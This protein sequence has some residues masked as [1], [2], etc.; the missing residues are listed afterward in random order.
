MKEALALAV[1][2]TRTTALLIESV[3]GQPRLVAAGRALSSSFGPSGDVVAGA[4]AAVTQV[5]SAVGRTL[6][7]LGAL[8]TPRREDGAGVASAAIV[9][10]ERPTV[11]LV[12]FGDRNALA[13]ARRALASLDA[14]LDEPV[15][16]SATADAAELAERLRPRSGALTAIVVVGPADAPAMARLAEAVQLAWPTPGTIPPLLW[17]GETAGVAVAR[18]VLQ[19][20]FNLT[21]V[22][23]VRRGTESEELGPLREA[24]ADLWRE[25]LDAALPGA[26]TVGKWAPGAPCAWRRGEE[27]A[28]GYLATSRGGPVWLARLV[29]EELSLL[30]AEP[31]SG[32]VPPRVVGA[33]AEL[34]LLAR[35][36]RPWSVPGTP[37]AANDLAAAVIEALRAAAAQLPADARPSL[38]GAAGLLIAGGD[39]ALLP[40]ETLVHALIDGLEPS[41]LLQL[42]VDEPDAL[43]ALGALAAV[44]PAAAAPVL[45]GELLRP[46]GALVAPGWRGRAGG[47]SFRFEARGASDGGSLA[48]DGILADETRRVA[49]AEGRSVE[50]RALRPNWWDPR[51]YLGRRLRMTIEGGP[52]G[53]V[54]DGRARPFGSALSLGREPIVDD[55]A[56]P[57]EQAGPV[58]ARP[59]AAGPLALRR[60]R[61]LPAGARLLVAAGDSVEPDEL[62][63]QAPGRGDGANPTLLPAGKQ[64]GVAD[65]R[66]FLTRATGTRVQAGDVI[67]RRSTLFGLIQR[68]VVA[69]VD[70]VLAAGLGGFGNLA[71]VPGS[72]G[73]GIAAHLPGVVVGKLEDAIVIETKAGLIAGGVGFG[74]E[75][76]GLLL[77]T[78]GRVDGSS[79]A[80]AAGRLAGAVVALDVLDRPQ[81]ELLRAAGAAGVIVGSVEPGLA[82]E[83][84]LVDPGLVVIATEGV[85]S[86]PLPAAAREVLAAHVGGLACLSAGRADDARAWP[87]AIFPSA[88][89][90][91]ARAL[92][93]PALAVGSRVRVIG[94]AVQH[95]R[96]VAVPAA[97][98]RLASGLVTAV[99][100]VELEGGERVRPALSNLELV[101]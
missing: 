84:A 17:A 98:D 94:E 12:G 50:V 64:L 33:R 16:V 81:Y 5:E 60:A 86:A 43:A 8:L 63:A 82:A 38:A 66:P 29:G 72:D 76:R 90:E 61:P 101:G 77:P 21:I 62:V 27:I 40:V 74:G 88:T 3:D 1:S 2:S 30:H 22:G 31:A 15:E 56:A 75:R 67:A 57:V 80:R 34:G 52:V 28:L 36:L 41:G 35:S 70:G 18:A 13:S 65:P 46:L 92:P 24:V 100:E 85:G 58:V 37:S 45:T 26:G 42:A 6:F 95:G 68:T 51:R 39:L 47:L 79:E 93:E 11:R 99:V 71:I 7:A 53:L 87:E 23:P 96:V 69:P 44:A 10:E 14:R 25:R 89:A 49:L 32:D 9:F 4:R 97:P 59:I 54:L 20:R 73:L 55:A 83:L 91:R 78:V 48:G 19:P